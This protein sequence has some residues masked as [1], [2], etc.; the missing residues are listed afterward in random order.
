MSNPDFFQ[1]YR[2]IIALPSI[3]STDPAWD[4]SNNPAGSRNQRKIQSD[5][6]LRQ[7]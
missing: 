2:D 4:Q 6:H 3:S 5:R 7:W 1:M